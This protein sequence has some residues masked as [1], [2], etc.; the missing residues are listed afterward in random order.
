MTNQST[1]SGKREDAEKS[2][3]NLHDLNLL[4]L[5]IETSIQILGG[6]IAASQ[7]F[8]GNCHHKA[9]LRARSLSA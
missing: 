4:R 7:Q 3:H 8:F 9:P 2:A 1:L 6:M 5:T